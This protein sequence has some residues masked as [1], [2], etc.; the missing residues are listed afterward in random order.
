MSDGRLRTLRNDCNQPAGTCRDDYCLCQV[1][2]DAKQRC[3]DKGEGWRW[4]IGR[5]SG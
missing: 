1:Y 2:A 4:G 5:R 3:I